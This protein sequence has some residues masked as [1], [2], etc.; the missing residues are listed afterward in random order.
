MRKVSSLMSFRLEETAELKD[1]L[2]LLMMLGDDRNIKETYI[3]GKRE[4]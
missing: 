2:F 4:Y 1:K 3:I